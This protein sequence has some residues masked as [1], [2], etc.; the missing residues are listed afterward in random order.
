MQLPKSETWMLFQCSRFLSR[1][2]D[3]SSS[4]DSTPLISLQSTFFSSASMTAVQSVPFCS[5][6]Y[7]SLLTGVS[8]SSLAP[9]SS[10]PKNSF[11]PNSDLKKKKKKS[12]ESCSFATKKC[13]PSF[14]Y[15]K[16]KFK[17][18]N[19]PY[20]D[21]TDLVLS[22]QDHL[23]YNTLWIRIRFGYEWQKNEKYQWYKLLESWFFLF[24]YG[25]Y[26]S[27]IQNPSSF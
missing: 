14:H 10:L 15:F 11:I 24:T 25:W 17:F 23:L 12:N 26:H 6:T 2:M 21:F 4:R 9:S 7:S 1:H 22:F 8:A 27:D 5:A 18:P 16:M 19:I 13:S 3:K 20:N